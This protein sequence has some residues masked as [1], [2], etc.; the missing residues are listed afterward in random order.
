MVQENDARHMRHSH[1]KSSWWRNVGRRCLLGDVALGSAGFGD[2]CSTL[3]VVAVDSW[4][5]EL[6]CGTPGGQVKEI[7]KVAETRLFVVSARV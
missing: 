2:R 4:L 7:V 5:G 1:I 6:S 3:V